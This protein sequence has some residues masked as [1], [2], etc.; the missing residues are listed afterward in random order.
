MLLV[1]GRGIF[2]FGCVDVD[3]VSHLGHLQVVTDECMYTEYA[4]KTEFGEYGL[5]NRLVTDWTT[6]KENFS[7]MTQAGKKALNSL[8]K[9]MNNNQT[10]AFWHNGEIDDECEYNGFH[11]HLVVGL[12]MALEP[13]SSYKAWRTVRKNILDQAAHQ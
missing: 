2:F 10:I 5:V 9:F 3:I 12:I 7:N 4:P 13:L 6:Q 1:T 8:K 11:M